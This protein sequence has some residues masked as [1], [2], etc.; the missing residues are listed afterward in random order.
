MLT[1]ARYGITAT[2][3][4][5]GAL[6][7]VWTVRVPALA[8][9]LHLDPGQLG[10]TVLAWGIGALVIMQVTGRLLTRFG[11]RAVLRVVGPATAATLALIGL[12]PSY[13]LLL[14]A[15]VVFGMTFAVLDIAMNAQAAR[16]ERAY[17]RPLMNGMHAGWSIGAVAGGL[18]GAATAYAGWSFTKAVVVFAVA[19]VPIAVALSLT[20]LPDPPAA[21][22]RFTARRGRL[23]RAVYLLGAVAFAAFMIEGSV[24]DWSGLYLR[25]TLDATEGTAALAYPLFETAMI[26]GRLSGD[27]VRAIVGDRRL[28][29]LAGLG[30][31][32]ACALVVAAP[33]PGFALAAFVVLGL[34]VCTVIPV[35][36]SLA[37]RMSPEAIARTNGLG[38]LGLLLGPTLIGPL[39]DATSLRAGF[40]VGVVV[41]VVLAVVARALPAGEGYGRDRSQN[42]VGVGA[43]HHDPR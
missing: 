1:R 41:A 16:V 34:A 32:A 13:L 14:G 42:A 11:S 21:A 17:G 26:V 23:P 18:L 22:G 35:A 15:A 7:A 36:F 30:T 43:L 12:A 31:A 39:A 24:A 3:G 38:Y 10:I 29:V 20:Y 2:F 40:T 37:G 27:R 9:K 5:A 19:G 8:D 4:L 25:D 6:A 33:G 28:L